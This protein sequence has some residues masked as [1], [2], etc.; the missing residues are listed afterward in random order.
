MGVLDREMIPF[1]LVSFSI[2]RHNQQ[3]P[4]ALMIDTNFSRFLTLARTLFKVWEIRGVVVVRK[5]DG[6]ATKGS[7]AR[8]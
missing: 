3:R 8:Q 2:A 7:C 6:T 1:S 5:K 4:C